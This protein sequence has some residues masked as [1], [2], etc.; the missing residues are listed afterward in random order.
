MSKFMDE[1][2]TDLSNILDDGSCMVGRELT[3]IMEQ[4]ST[5]QRMAEVGPFPSCPARHR[6]IVQGFWGCGPL[7]D[8]G[9][10]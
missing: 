6:R 9:Q 3:K 1:I 10:W 7:Q 2:R 4:L 5:S 8:R